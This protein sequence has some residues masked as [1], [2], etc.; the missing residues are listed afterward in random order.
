MQR[1]WAEAAEALAGWTL[2]QMAVRRDVYGH[3]DDQGLLRTC[4][5]PTKVALIEHCRGESVVA[6]HTTSSENQVRLLTIDLD[7]NGEAAD[8]AIGVRDRDHG[9]L[10]ARQLQD[11]GLEVWLLDSDGRAGDHLKAWPHRAT[12]R[13]GVIRRESPRLDGDGTVSLTA[14]SGGS[15]RWTFAGYRANAM[16]V[17]GLSLLT[18]CRVAFDNLATTFD[19]SLDFEL[20]D[21]DPRPPQR[22]DEGSSLPQEGHPDERP[23][24]GMQPVTRHAKPEVDGESF[25]PGRVGKPIILAEPS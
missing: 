3:Y 13:L 16:F 20:M 1:V 17:A 6:P 15:E 12:E 10:E 21:A 7:A 18:R 4:I 22:H 24:T 19:R 9:L 8:S 23:A 5:G 25:E 11:R 2:S 14:A